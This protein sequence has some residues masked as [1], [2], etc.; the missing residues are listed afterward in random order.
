MSRLLHRE[1]LQQPDEVVVDPLG[2]H[3]STADTAQQKLLL[4]KQ[5]LSM[6]SRDI[7][8]QEWEL[9]ILENFWLKIRIGVH[10]FVLN[11]RPLN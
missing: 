1:Q 7:W 9:Q 10:E 8:R 3:A 5:A 4:V 2:A 11:L 6:A